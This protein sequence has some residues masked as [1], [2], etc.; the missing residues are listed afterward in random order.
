MKT[1]NTLNLHA[2]CK[3][4]QQ[5]RENQRYMR[6]CD[7]ERIVRGEKPIYPLPWRNVRHHLSLLPISVQHAVLS[8]LIR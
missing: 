7:M 2:E 6:R 3:N 1:A 5:V 8:L 4:I